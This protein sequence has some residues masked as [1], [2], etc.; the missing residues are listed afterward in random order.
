MSSGGESFL[1]MML[2]VC[3]GQRYADEGKYTINYFQYQDVVGC[4]AMSCGG[5][6]FS[7]YGAYDYVWDSVKPMKEKIHHLFLPVPRRC[8]VC[9]LAQGLDQQL[10][11]FLRRQPQL[12]PVQ[13]GGHGSQC[14][15]CSYTGAGLW[16]VS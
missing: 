15:L 7:P 14:S 5:E 12:L 8:W 2:T 1:P 11:R 13:V 16:E 3:V 9:F 10:L 4:V 6:S